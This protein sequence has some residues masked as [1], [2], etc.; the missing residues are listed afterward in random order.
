MRLR[1]AR[2]GCENGSQMTIMRLETGVTHAFVSV[3]D[4]E[5]LEGKNRTLN[6]KK[7]IQE[8]AQKLQAGEQQLLEL[9]QRLLELDQQHR[10]CCW[11]G[12]ALTLKLKF[13]TA[14]TEL[15]AEVQKQ[16]DLDWLR[17]FLASIESAATVE[18]LRRLLP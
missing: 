10:E 2:D 1:D 8:M 15:F 7:L 6:Q 18:E 17:R 3:F 12:I 11:Q 4:Q 13:A 5:I 16:T 9:D 14:G